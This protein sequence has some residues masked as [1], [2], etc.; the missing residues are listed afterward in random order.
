MESSASNKF[1]LSMCI[2]KYLFWIV[3]IISSAVYFAPI[4]TAIDNRA[5]KIFD[6]IGSIEYGSLKFKVRNY[7]QKSG[8]LKL[9][10]K[11]SGMTQKEIETL[12]FW[13]NGQ[14]GI[15]SYH[16]KTLFVGFPGSWEVL[17]SLAK[18]ELVKPSEDVSQYRKR[19][20][21][22]GFEETN[23]EAGMIEYSTEQALTSEQISSLEL[24]AVKTSKGV[25]LTNLIVHVVASEL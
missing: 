25:E 1:D 9:A 5:P 23:S 12:L 22:M 4:K 17:D 24:D 10:G 15:S 19:I 18:K 2:I 6:N 11:L 16:D 21:S 8:S 13:G 3:V 7:A 14:W 20:L